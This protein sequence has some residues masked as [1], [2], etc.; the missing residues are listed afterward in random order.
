MIDFIVYDVETQKMSNQVEGGWNNIYGMGLAS[1]VTYSSADDQYLFWQESERED[2]CKYLNN[3]L[4]VSFNG[5]TFDSK[6]LLGDDRILLPNGTT[7]NNKYSWKNADIF[8]ETWRRILNLDRT[9]YPKIVEEI[10]KQEMQQG[11]FSLDGIANATLNRSKSGKGS[12][13]CM[14]YQQRKYIELFNYNLQDVRLTKEL[15]LFIM[16]YKYLVTGSYD[17]VLFK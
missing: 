5:L 17:I 3:Q 7:Q 8:I 6:L 4:V 9:N 16:K 11:I 13:A 1:A 14:L 10:N 12:N 2:L 15:Y